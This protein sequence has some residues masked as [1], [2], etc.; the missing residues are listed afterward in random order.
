MNKDTRINAKSMTFFETLGIFIAM[1]AFSGFHM[2]IYTAVGE[3]W[4]DTGEYTIYYINSM[5]GYVLFVA[6]A[7]TVF[8]AVMRKYSLGRP[9]Q[10]VS[11]AARKIAGGDFSIR[12]E[13]LRK[14]G[15]KDYIEI[16]F[17]DFNKMAEELGSIEA[18]KDDFI[19][20]VSH[21]IKT[22]LAVIQNYTAAL[23]D[24]SLTS[25]QRKEYHATII[26]ATGRL[27][28]LVTNILKLNRLDN[29]EIVMKRK[30]YD[31]SEQVRQCSL[32]FEDVWER[33]EITFEADIE[34]DVIVHCDA[35]MLEIVWNNLM[36]NAIKFTEPGGKVAFRLR[37]E[38]EEAVVSVTDTGCGM[39][40]ETG[41]HIFDKFY[42]G[43]TSRAQEG[44]GL[45]LALVKRVVAL[46]DGDI[47]VGSQIG[48]GSTFTV[49]LKTQ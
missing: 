14:D 44:N 10:R 39:S 49:R 20:N 5:G 35:S 41:A 48:E 2:W 32:A 19:S 25:E 18:L 7:M 23:D 13:P 30:P 27:S 21:E 1:M 36:S 34:D 8:T 37:R 47:T 17:D 12:L 16:M 4:P 24:T 42:Q 38:N 40:A 46:S 29:Q 31:L 11:E 9:M 28:D 3:K 6:L 45:G 43:D 22:P 15:K 26:S 33:K